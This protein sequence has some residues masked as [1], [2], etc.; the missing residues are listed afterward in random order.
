[1]AE[2]L[3]DHGHEVTVVTGFPRY[4][5]DEVDEKYRGK[6]LMREEVDGIQVIRLLLT[7]ALGRRFLI[8]KMEY[9]LVFPIFF[10]GA[11]LAGPQDVAVVYSPPVPVG[12]SAY[13]LQKIRGTPF[14]LNVQD[15]HPQA[16]IDLGFLKNK[17]LISVLRKMEQLVYQA[18]SFITVHSKGNEQYLLEHGVDADKA[19]VVGNWVDTEVIRPAERLNGFREE[20]NLGEDFIV[21]FAGTMGTSQDLWTVIQAAD[22][23]REVGDLRFVLVGDGVEKPNLER[24]AAR[25]ELENV[26][27]LPMQPREKY[28]QVLAASDVCLVTLKKSVV[29]PV[30]PSKLLSIMAA[31]RPAV[32]SV[33]LGGDAPEIVKEAEAGRC[34]EPENAEQ[35][36][37]A[38]LELYRNPSLAR[39]LG[40]NARAYAEQY[41]S[42]EACIARYESL[43]EQI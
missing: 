27:F 37:S 23:L 21:S 22:S 8:R 31:G 39:Q 19:V 30:V 40:R 14:V 10:L 26:V 29:T 5:V 41:F 2:V 20:Y 3:V 9:F 36:S 33:F 17:M 18:A 4:N 12:M 32:L 28:P 1:L 43:F 35:L 38:L 13:L 25:L 24:E 34:V 6:L 7:H 16:L 15:L 42:K 11:L